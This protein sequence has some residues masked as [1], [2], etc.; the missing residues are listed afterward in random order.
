MIPSDWDTAH[1]VVVDGA[2]RGRVSLTDPATAGQ[3]WVDDQWIAVPVP[4]YATDVPARVQ[5]LGAQA[6]TVVT[7]EEQQVVVDHLVVVP[8]GMA[9]V[10]PGHQV[11]VTDAADPDLV[12]S[13]LR[14]EYVALGTER[15]ERDLYCTLT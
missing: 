12:G 13:V 8:W 7:A 2:L 4:P 11:T 14:V 3:A 6:R 5:R 15:F 9:E 10:R 1:A